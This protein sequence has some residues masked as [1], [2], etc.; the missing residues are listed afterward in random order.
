MVADYQLQTN[1][2]GFIKM[3]CV[4]HTTLTVSGIDIRNIIC[5]HP[6]LKLFIQKCRQVN[7]ISCRMN[8]DWNSFEFSFVTGF[9]I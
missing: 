1:T 3:N 7:R 4:E 9:P 8:G 5:K 2:F 6:M